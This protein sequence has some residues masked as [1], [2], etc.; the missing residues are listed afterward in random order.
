MR[1]IPHSFS[2]ACL[3]A[4]L[5]IA[6]PAQQPAE[7]LNDTCPVME[8]EPVGDNPVVVEYEGRKINLCC[9]KCKRLFFEDPTKYLAGLPQFADRVKPTAIVRAEPA[10]TAAA[11]A[12][13]TVSAGA[14][15][16]ASPQEAA[17]F[18]DWLGRFH[19]VTVHF[20][21]A[22]IVLAALLEIGAVLRGRGAAEAPVR[23]LLLW[24][25]TLGL[26]SCGLG[27]LHADSM[28]FTGARLDVFT[29]HYRFAWTACGWAC[30]A[31]LAAG[32]AARGGTGM[33]WSFRVLL[34]GAGLFVGL[35]GHAGGRLTQ[36]LSF[37]SRG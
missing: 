21:I 37:F 31:W 12:T 16:S 34:L 1:P 26:C 18:L 19:V 23:L 17:P 8:G 35:T 13:T 9:K 27:L 5:A 2:C 28:E 24:G 6:C 33:R 14:A 32:R 20:P 15:L 3:L 7:I 25:W 30:G 4:I 10:S 36:G 22:L 11:V 29:D